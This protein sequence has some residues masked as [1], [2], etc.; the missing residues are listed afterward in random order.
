MSADNLIAILITRDT[1]HSDGNG[2]SRPFDGGARDV[3]RV[4]HTSNPESFEYFLHNEI[5]NLGYWMNEVFARAQVVLDE[6]TAWDLA[7]KMADTQPIL[8][9]GIQVWDARPM[10]FPNH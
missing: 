4:V 6:N 9:H 7:R 5:H 10:N 8:E 2:W 3:F 1:H